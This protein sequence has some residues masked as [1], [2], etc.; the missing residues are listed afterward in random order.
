MN[1]ISLHISSIDPPTPSVE[2]DSSVGLLLRLG[3]NPRTDCAASIRNRVIKKERENLDII[4]RTKTYIYQHLFPIL[5]EVQEPIEGNLFFHHETTNLCQEFIQKQNNIIDII[6]I[7]ESKDRIDILEIGFNA[8]FSTVLCLMANP[9][10][11]LTCI[12]IGFH[13]YTYACYEKIKQTFGDRIRFF[14][15]NSVDVLP[16]IEDT[17]D[18]FHLDGSHEPEII[19][20]DLFHVNRLSHPGSILI[21]NDTHDPNVKT[22]FETFTFSCWKS[23]ILQENTPYHIIRQRYQNTSLFTFPILHQTNRD[24]DI[25]P[26]KIFQLWHSIDDLSE[27]M[28]L[29]TEILKTQHPE[30]E[31]RLFF[32]DTAREFIQQYFESKVVIAFDTIIPFAFKSDLWR[33]DKQSC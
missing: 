4:E 17:F 19:S 21:L 25:V 33:Q 12:D 23:I 5:Q 1:S 18:I 29:R 28:I 10:T 8:G 32:L 9:N 15:G 31:Y 6:T 2:L 20:S 30:Y 11:Y 7:L 3:D 27:Q 16:K 24:I 26:K 14:L 22:T 13:R